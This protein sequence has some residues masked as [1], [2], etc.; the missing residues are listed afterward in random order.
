[1]SDGAITPKPILEMANAFWQSKA[2][3]VAVELGLFTKMTGKTVTVQEVSSMLGI[4]SRPAQ[5][6]T[7]ACTALGLL[8]KEN[9]NLFKNT[10]L[11]ETFLVFGTPT[12][13]G[14]VVIH[15]GDFLYK[16]WGGIKESIL[17]DAPPSSGTAKKEIEN[18]PELARE[19]TIVM[20][21]L[22]IPPAKAIAKMVDFASY[23]NMLDLGGGSGVFSI[24]I[25]KECPHLKATIFDVPVVCD[26][27]AEYVRKEKMEDRIR[28]V[29][30]DF[31]KDE[32]PNSHD[33]V[34]ISQVLHGKDS[35]ACKLVLAKVF[36]VLPKGGKIIINE[37]LLND[38]ETG[39]LF[40]ALFSLNML[41]MTEKG[42]GYSGRTLTNWLE[43][44]GFTE[45]EKIE[46]PGPPT[47]ITAIRG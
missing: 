47:L 32:L 14:D 23:Y 41:V 37:Y 10:P 1:M 24:T 25:A 16:M 38:D 19:F 26:V 31:L 40:S 12:Y 45:I 28:I 46:L 36:K 5:M 29:E 2:L 6:L 22:A 35:E 15:F 44:V 42:I 17:S 18:D 4:N 34:L 9:K 21:S 20:N 7:T 27:A 39:P 3:T 13:L 8:E 43:E 11:S 33:I 30:G